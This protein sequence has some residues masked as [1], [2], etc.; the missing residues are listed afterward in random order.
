MNNKPVPILY[1]L[2]SE[3]SQNLQS[4]ANFGH[5]L[6]RNKSLRRR[7]GKIILLKSFFLEGLG[8]NEK[9]RLFS[10]IYKQPKDLREHA[11][12]NLR[13]RVMYAEKLSAR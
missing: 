8:L 3:N 10:E 6:A 2:F 12:R 4:L 5:Y 1:R 11:T 9:L 13:P 7:K